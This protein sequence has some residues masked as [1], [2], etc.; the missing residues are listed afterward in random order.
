MI[1]S[2]SRYCQRTVYRRKTISPYHIAIQVT[3][4][5]FTHTSFLFYIL[6][7]LPLFT[8]GKQFLPITPLYRCVTDRYISINILILSWSHAFFLFY[9]VSYTPFL[10]YSFLFPPSYPLFFSCRF[11]GSYVEVCIRTLCFDGRQKQGPEC[12]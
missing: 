8:G 7:Y 2:S 6:Y 1:W 9:I 10:A 5:P 11:C 12:L 4:Q 3:Y